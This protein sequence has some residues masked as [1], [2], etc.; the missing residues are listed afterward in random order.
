MKNHMRRLSRKKGNK[1]DMRKGWE[2]SN[3][4]EIKGAVGSGTVRQRMANL[5]LLRCV[6]MMMV[7]V[8]HYLGKGGLLTDLT[9]NSLGSV[10]VTA[11]LLESFCIVAVNVYMFISGYFLC[12]SSFKVSRLLQLWLQVWV[13]SVSLGL[14]G[15]L[16]GIMAENTFDIHYVLTLVFPVLMG[17][18]WFMTS[19]VFLYLLLPF[20]GMAASRM[21]KKQLQIG[22]GFLLFV[23]CIVKSILPLRLE[24]DEQGYNYLWYLCVFLTAAYVRRF[25]LPTPK[26]MNETETI[27][28]G[29]SLRKKGCSFGLYVGGCLL[30][31]VGTITLRAIYLHTGSLGRMLGMCMEYNHILPFL[32]SIGLFGVFYH[33]E[34]KGKTARI[35]TKIAPYTLG[36]YLLHENIGLRYTWQN[37]FGAEQIVHGTWGIVKGNGM[38]PDV[39]GLLLGA[40]AAVLCMFAGGIIVDMARERLFV[41]LHGL[42]LHIRIYRELVGLVEKADLTFQRT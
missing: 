6:A 8:L 17:H 39:V 30:I 23:F 29:F 2:G 38:L 12:M 14:L 26:E 40:G 25:W 27:G 18:Y 16:T 9:Q 34:I 7:V 24:M 20:V 15:A 22:L 32:A 37:W 13:Y 21:T 35:V 28:K 19:Y 11:W 4:R 10:G 31:F 33:M 1:L 3:T 41:F 5:E 42:F 36:V